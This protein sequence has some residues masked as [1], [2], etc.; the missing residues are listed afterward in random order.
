M[1]KKI[2][3]SFFAV[4]FITFTIVATLMGCDSDIFGNNQPTDITLS[5]TL[6]EFDTIKEIQGKNLQLEAT[7]T[8]KGGSK[9]KEVSWEFPSDDKAFKVQ[10]TAGG[11]LTFQ[12]YK[13]GTYVISA[14]AMYE[15]KAYKTAQ[16]VITINDALTHL[17]I[18]N[19]TDNNTILTDNSASMELM[20]GNTVTLAPVFTPESTSQ[21]TVLWSIDNAAVASISEQPGNKATLTAKS[22][23]T[24]TVSLISQDNTSIYRTLKLTVIE[25]G[26]EQK[27]GLS[28]I[29]VS[30]TEGAIEIGTS[31]TFTATVWD[32]NSNI[33]TSDKVAFSLTE[34]SKSA[35]QLGNVTDRSVSVT[36]THGGTGTLLA[37]FTRDGETVESKVPLSVTGNVENISVKSSYINLLKGAE[38]LVNVFYSPENTKEKGFTV[39]DYDPSIISVIENTADKDGSFYIRANNIGTTKVQIKSIYNNAIVAEIGIGVVDPKTKADRISRIEIGTP[40]LTVEPLLNENGEAYFDPIDLFASIYTISDNG[41]EDKNDNNYN[42]TF[43]SSDSSV[44]YVFDSSYVNADEG[45]KATL[46]VLKPGK[47]R[48]YAKSADNKTVTAYCDIT[49]NGTLKALIAENSAI[50]LTP[51]DKRTV[52]LTPNPYNAVMS[53]PSVSLSNDAVSA[54]IKRENGVYK[55][56]IEALKLGETTVSYYVDGKTVSTTRVTVG[57][58]ENNAVRTI[59]FKDITSALYL[60]Q[61]EDPKTFTVEALDSKGLAVNK[62]IELKPETETANEIVTIERV[63][64]TNTFTISPK[65]AGKGNWIFYINDTS[66]IKSVLHVEVGGS[67]VQGEDIRAIKAPFNS[68]S[69][70]LKDDGKKEETIKINTIPLGGEEVCGKLIWSISD[71]DVAELVTVPSDPTD[72][73][74]IVRAVGEG[75]A[76]IT[77]ET[78]KGLKTTINVRV[79]G[80]D[81]ATNTVISKAYIAKG[82]T[83]NWAMFSTVGESFELEAVAYN[84]DGSVA[85][86]ELFNWTYQGEGVKSLLMEKEDGVIATATTKASF[87]ISSMPQNGYDNPV[88]ITA[89]SVNN[90]AVRATFMVYIVASEPTEEKP[91]IIAEYSGVTLSLES[92]KT[93]KMDI[94][95]NV[96]P[97]SYDTSNME[98]T[99]SSTVVSAKLNKNTNTLSLTAQEAGNATV[100]V[101]DGKLSFDVSVNVVE[102]AIKED[103]K[104]TSIRL[105]RSYLSYDLADKA[106]Q[107]ITATVYKDGEEA[108]NEGV[109]WTSSD[110]SIVKISTSGKIAQVLPQDKVGTAFITATSIN[111]ANVS[112]SCSIEVIDSSKIA[113]TLRYINI[114]QTNVIL[115]EGDRMTLTV[116]GQPENLV[117]TAQLTWKSSKPDV[118]MVSNGTI[119]ALKEGEADITVSTVSDGKTFNAVCH[120]IVKDNKTEIK[121]VSSIKLSESIVRIPQDDMDKTFSINA[122]IYDQNSEEM[123]GRS[124]QWEVVNSGAEDAIEYTADNLSLSYIPKNPGKVIVKASIGAIKAEAIIYVAEGKGEDQSLK[125]IVLTPSV[126]IGINENYDLKATLIPA[127]ATDTIEWTVN[128]SNLKTTSSKNGKVLSVVSSKAG[129]YTLTASSLENPLISAT[130][131]VTVKEAIKEDEVTSVNLDVK[132]ILL[133]L[134]DKKLTSIKATVYKGGKVSDG[135]VE[136]KIDDSLKDVISYRTLGFNS[137]A[138]NKTNKTGEGYITAIS[139]DDGKKYAVCKVRVVDT[140][141]TVISD[142]ESANISS[143]TISLEKGKEH[144]LSVSTYPSIIPT[145]TEWYSSNE[146]VATVDTN[147]NIIA[148]GIGSATITASVH[149]REKTISLECRV[150]VY[151]PNDAISAKLIK[152]SQNVVYLKQD[153]MDKTVSVQATIIGSDNKEL[154][155]DSDGNQALVTWRIDNSNN[156]DA[157]ASISWADNTVLLTPKNAGTARV[158]AEYQGKE[159]SFIVVT[160][161]STTASSKEPTGVL[162]MPASLTMKTGDSAVISAYVQPTGATADYAFAVKEGSDVV[163]ATYSGNKVRIKAKKTGTAK[164]EAM[165]VNKPEIKTTLNITVVSST[166]KKVT[167]ISLDKNYIS[168]ELDTKALTTVSATAYV[169]G[170]ATKNIPLEWSLE[171]ITKNE[172]E[173]TLL[174]TYNTVSLT[175]K[176]VG[177]GYLVCR[178]KDNPDVYA[179]CRVEITKPE[180]KAV[181]AKRIELSKSL[182]TVSQEKMDETFVLDATV[183]GSD[184]KVFTSGSVS[185]TVTDPNSAIEYQK[186]DSS[187]FFSPRNAGV[188][189]VKASVGNVETEA[190]IIVGSAYSDKTLKGYTL[191][192]TR[193]VLEE[194]KSSIIRLLPIPADAENV[195]TI[196]TSSAPDIA[197]VSEINDQMVVTAQKV[198]SATITAVDVNDASIKAIANVTVVAKGVITSETVTALTL[199]KSHI[200]LDLASKDLTSVK[201]TVYKNGKASNGAVEWKIDESLK[202]VVTVPILGNTISIV[203]KAVGEGYIT[204]TSKDDRNFSARVY[205]QVIDSSILPDKGI[206]D[207]TISSQSITLKKG[208]KSTYTVSVLPEDLAYNTSWFSSDETIATVDKN[209]TVTA[210]NNGRATISARLSYKDQVKYV[211]STV[212]VYSESSATRPAFVTLSS[213]VIRLSM[214]SENT[215][216][217]VEARVYDENNV[218]MFGKEI[219]WSIKDSSVARIETNNENKTGSKAYLYPISAGSTIVTATVGNIE[220]TVLVIVGSKEQGAK[221]STTGIVFN[222]SSAILK[223]GETMVVSANLIPAGVDDEILYSITAPSI[224]SGEL[225]ADKTLTVKGANAGNANIIARSKKNPSISTQM[226]VNVKDSVKNA[227][228]AIKLDKT[229]IE[230]DLNEKALVSLKA[231]V[232]VDGKETIE[233]VPLVWSFT[234]TP[235][236]AI[237]LH[238]GTSANNVVYVSKAEV[239]SGYITCRADNGVYAQCYVEVIES[240]DP[241]YGLSRIVFSDNIINLSQEKMDEIHAVKATVYNTNNEIVDKAITWTL[242]PDDKATITKNGNVVYLKPLNAGEAILSAKV[243]DGESTITNSIKVIVGAAS[244]VSDELVKLLAQPESLV[245][246]KG[247]TSAISISTIPANAKDT[248]EW[249]MTNSSNARLTIETS[250]GTKRAKVEGLIVGKTTVTAYSKENP[251][252]KVEIPVSIVENNEAYNS[253][254][255]ALKLDKSAIYLDLAEKTMTTLKATV[256]VGGKASTKAVTNWNVDESLKEVISTQEIGN[257]TLSITKKSVGKG[258][259][260]ATVVEGGVTY[261]A[262]AYVEVVDTS[263]TTPSLVFITLSDKV[264]TLTEGNSATLNVTGYSEEAFKN[265]AITWS[266]DNEDVAVVARGKVTALKE[267]VARIKA[268]VNGTSISDECVVTVKKS[269]SPIVPSRVVVSEKNIFLT[270]GESHA[271]YAEIVPEGATATLTW[272]SSD[273]SIVKV[274]KDGIISAIKAGTANITVFNST[275]NITDSCSVTVKEPSGESKVTTAIVFNPRT[276]TIHKGEK[277]VINVNGSPVEAIDEFEYST[278]NPNVV[279]ILSDESDNT[280]VVFTA[281]GIGEAKI[282]AVS[283]NSPLVKAECIVKVVSVNTEIKEIT[284]IVLSNN[285]GKIYEGSKTLYVAQAYMGS[286]KA[287]AKIEWSLEGLTSAQAEIISADSTGKRAYLDAKKNGEGY[288]VATVKANGTTQT[289][290]VSTKTYVQILEKPTIENPTAPTVSKIV[291]SG[292]PIVQILQSSEGYTVKATVLDTNGDITD[293]NVSWNSSNEDVATILSSGNTALIIPNEAGQSIISATAEGKTESILVIVGAINT[294]EK[295]KGLTVR[296]NPLTIEV[297]DNWTLEATTLPVGAMDVGSFAWASDNPKVARVTKNATN[298]LKAD[299]VAASVGSAKITVYSLNNPLISATTEVEVKAKGS[300]KSDSVTAIELSKNQLSL[301]LGKDNA[302]SVD[303]IVYKNKVKS[304]S[305][306]VT[307]TKSETDAFT[308]TQIGSKTVNIVPVKEGEGYITAQS[309]DDA[310]FKASCYVRVTKTEIAGTEIS[311]IK[312]SPEAITL[313][314]NAKTTFSVSVYPSTITDYTVSW[315]SSNDTIVSVTED[316]VATAKSSGNAR[317]T[318]TIGYKGKTYS[319]YGT[320]SVSDD[321]VTLNRIELSVKDVTLRESESIQVSAELIPSGANAK[322]TWASSNANVARVNSNGVITGIK[323]GSAVITAHAYDEDMEA[324]VN[325]E[326]IEN[327]KTVTPGSIRLSTQI[328]QLDQLKPDEEKTV[329]ATVYAKEDNAPIADAVVTWTI[330]DESVAKLDTNKNVATLKAGDAGKTALKAWYGSLSSTAVIYSG[331]TPTS[332]TVLDRLS[333]SPSVIAIETDKTEKASVKGFP[334]GASFTP[335]WESNNTQVATI[336]DETKNANIVTINGVKEGQATITVKDANADKK[337]TL[338]VKVY[339]DISNAVTGVYLDKSGLSFDIAEKS[340][341]TV[342]AKVYVNKT[343]APSEKVK[344]TL[345]NEDLITGSDLVVFVPTDST[346]LTI[347]LKPNASRTIKTGKAYLRATSVKDTDMY[348]QVFIEVV[349]SSTAPVKVTEILCETDTATLPVGSTRTFRAVTYPDSVKADVRWMVIDQK[350]INGTGNVITTDIYGKVT[351]VSEGSATLKAYVY[352]SSPELSDTVAITVTATGNADE[353]SKYEIGS[354]RLSPSQLLLSQTATFPTTLTARIYDKSGKE[355]TTEQVNWNIDGI[356]DI[357]TVVRTQGNVLYLEAKS[358]GKGEIIASKTGADGKTITA[359]AYVVTGGVVNPEETYITNLTFNRSMPIYLVAGDGKSETA[360]LRYTPESKSAEGTVWSSRNYD[361][362]IQFATNNT[363]ITATGLKE[364]PANSPVVVT[365]TSASKDVNNNSLSADAIFKVVASKDELPEVTSLTLDK[366]RLVLD[367]SE[368]AVAAVTATAF[369]A[370]GKVVPGAKIEWELRNNTTTNVS[371]TNTTGPTVGVNKGTMPGKVELVATCGEVEIVCNVEVIDSSTFMGISVGSKEIRLVKGGNATISVYGTPSDMFKE[372]SCSVSGD[373]DAVRIISDGTKKNF[374]VTALKAGTAFLRFITEVNGKLYT[375]D[376]VVYVNDPETRSVNS[377]SFTPKSLYL[378]YEGA[379]ADLTTILY[380]K[381]GNVVQESVE[382][383]AEDPSIVELNKTQ[384]G[385]EVTA[386]KKGATSVYA[387]S[388]GVSSQSYIMVG[389]KALADDKLVKIIPSMDNVTMKKNQVQDVALTAVPASYQFQNLVVASN[390]TN[391]ATASIENGALRIKALGEGTAVITV[392]EA[393]VSTDITVT[394]TGI[395]QPA[396]IEFDKQ[397]VSLKQESTSSETVNAYVY[398]QDKTLL[399]L[400]IALWQTSDS[401]IA[402]ITKKNANSITVTPGNMG[403]AKVTANVGKVSSSFPVFVNAVEKIADAP[404]DIKAAQANIKLAVGDTTEVNVF[405]EPTNVKET[406]KG[407]TWNVKDTKIASIVPLSNG[408]ASVTG[409]TVGKT[410]ITAKSNVG[411]DGNKPS[412]VFNVTVVPETDKDVYRIELD[413]TEI[414]LNFSK[415]S[416]INAHLYKNNVEVDASEINWT[417]EAQQSVVKLSFV[418]GVSLTDKYTGSGVGI[419][420]GTAAGVV[421][422]VASYANT[423]SRA[424]VVIS[425]SKQATT[426]LTAVAI[427]SKYMVMEEGETV[428]FT[429]TTLPQIAGVTYTWNSSEKDLVEFIAINNNT[430]TLKALKKGSTKISVVATLAG[431]N[432]PVKDESVLRIE[433][434]GALDTTYKYS[435]VK[436]DKTSLTMLPNGSYATVTATLVDK[437][438]KEVEAAL[439]GWDILDYRGNVLVS[440][441]PN[442]YT[443]GTDTKTYSTLEAVIKAAK[444][445][446][447]SI[448]FTQFEVIGANNSIVH[449]TPTVSGIFFIEAKGPVENNKYVSSKMMLEVS[450]GITG[451]GFNSSYLHLIKGEKVQ[452]TVSTSPTNAQLTAYQWQEKVAT[453]GGKQLIDIQDATVSSAYLFGREIGTTAVE[454]TA[455]DTTGVSMNAQMTV[456]VHDPSYGTGGIRNISFDN[457]YA[458]ASYP[459]QTATYKATAY[460]MDGTTAEDSDITYK[461]FNSDGS[462]ATDG[463]ITRGEGYDTKIATFTITENGVRITPFAKGTVKVVATLNKDGAEF[464]AEMY[465][466][467]VGNSSQLTPSSSSI[468]LYTGGSAKID[469]TTDNGHNNEYEVELISEYTKD[470]HKIVGGFLEGTETVMQSVFTFLKSTVKGNSVTLGTKALLTEGQRKSG[471]NYSGSK[472]LLTDGGEG[473]LTE[474]QYNEIVATFPRTAAFKVTTADGQSSTIINVTVNQLPT[475]NSYPLELTLDISKVDLTPPFTTENTVKASLKDIANRETTGTINWYYYPVGSEIDEDDHK[476]DTKKAVDKDTISAYFSADGKTMYYT[477][478][479]SGLYRLKAE[480]VQNPQLT[481]IATI[482]VGGSVTG[483]TSSVGSSLRIEKGAS[484]TVSAVFTPESALARTAYFALDETIKAPNGAPLSRVI[485]NTKLDNNYLSITV[486]NG[487]ETGDTATIYG[488]LSTGNENRQM[489]RIIYPQTTAGESTLNSLKGKGCFYTLTGTTMKA[490]TLDTEGNVIDKLDTNGKPI[491]IEVFFY[492]VTVDVYANK[493]VYAFKASGATEV[494]PNDVKG[495]VLTYNVTASTNTSNTDN[496]F[497]NWDWVEAKLVGADT[498]MVYASSVPVDADGHS[499]YQATANGEV[500]VKTENGDKA[501]AVESGKYYPESSYFTTETKGL[502]AKDLKNYNSK[503]TVLR[504]FADIE[505]DGITDNAYKNAELVSNKD[506]N[507]FWFKATGAEFIAGTVYEVSEESSSENPDDKQYYVNSK[508]KKVKVFDTKDLNYA[509]PLVGRLALVEVPAPLSDL[510]QGRLLASENNSVYKFTLNSSAIPTEP[511]VLRAGISEKVKEENKN[512]SK[513]YDTE[514]TGFTDSDTNVFI[515]G[516]IQSISPGISE[517]KNNGSSSV[518]TADGSM[519]QLIEGASAIIKL[520]YNPSYTHQREVRWEVIGGSTV[521]NSYTITPS[522]DSTQLS[523]V[524]NKIDANKD[525]ETVHLRATSIYNPNVYCDFTVVIQCIVKSMSF[526]TKAMT[527]A[528]T[529]DNK[530]QPIYRLISDQINY[531]DKQ[532][533]DKVECYDYADVAGDAA[534]V[535]AYLIEMTPT[536][537]FGYNFKAEIIEGSNIG[538]LDTTDLDA[539]SNSFRF[540]PKGRVYEKYDENGKPASSAY[541]VEYGNVTIRVTCEDLNYSKDFTINYGASAGRI[542]RDIENPH[543]GDNWMQWDSATSPDGAHYLYGLEAIVLY[544]GETFPVTMIDFNSGD[545]GNDQG[546]F[547]QHWT[548]DS[549]DSFIKWYVADGYGQVCYDGTNYYADMAGNATASD[550][551]WTGGI[552]FAT[553]GKNI[554]TEKND[555]RYTDDLSDVEKEELLSEKG[556]LGSVCILKAE[557]QGIFTL[558]YTLI[559]ILKNSETGEAILDNDGNPC[560]ITTVGSIPVYVISRANQTMLAALSSISQLKV[561]AYLCDKYISK[562]N[563]DKWF[564]PARDNGITDSKTNLQAN[565]A[566]WRGKTFIAFDETHEYG[567]KAKTYY[568]LSDTDFGSGTDNTLDFSGLSASDFNSA[569]GYA[570]SIF[571]AEEESSTVTVN[572]SQTASKVDY[573]NN[574]SDVLAVS[575][576]NRSF[577][578]INF[579]NLVLAGDSGIAILKATHNFFVGKNKSADVQQ[580]EWV[581]NNSTYVE[582]KGNVLDFSGNNIESITFTNLDFENTDGILLRESTEL[583]SGN[584]LKSFAMI[585]CDFLN[586]QFYDGNYAWGDKNTKLVQN[587]SFESVGI[588]KI[589]MSNFTNA[590]RIAF[591]GTVGAPSGE[592]SDFANS[593]LILE[594]MKNSGEKD[595]V[596]FDTSN[597]SDLHFNKMEI[598]NSNLTE[599]D[600]ERCISSVREMEIDKVNAGN[601]LSIRGQSL[602]KLSVTGG[603]TLNAQKEKAVFA[604]GAFNASLGVKPSLTIDNVTIS[605]MEITATGNGSNDAPSGFNQISVKNSNTTDIEIMGVGSYSNTE[606]VDIANINSNGNVKITLSAINSLKNLNITTIPRLSTLTLSNV[607]SKE[608]ANVRIYNAGYN[609]NGFTIEG[610]GTVVKMLEIGRT[611]DGTQ[612]KLASI[613]NPIETPLL[614]LNGVSASNLS[615]EGSTI[616]KIVVGDSNINNAYANYIGT[617]DLAKITNNV[618]LYLNGTKNGDNRIGTINATSKTVDAIQVTNEKGNGS[619]TVNNFNLDGATIHENSLRAAIK[620]VGGDN[621]DQ[622]TAKRSKVI[623]SSNTIKFSGTGTSTVTIPG[624]EVVTTTETSVARLSELIG[625]NEADAK[626]QHSIKCYDYFKQESVPSIKLDANICTTECKNFEDGGLKLHYHAPTGEIYIM[627][628]HEK[629]QDIQV[630]TTKDLSAKELTEYYKIVGTE[631]VIKNAKDNNNDQ[632]LFKYKYSSGVTIEHIGE[633]IGNGPNK[634]HNKDRI[635]DGCVIK[636]TTRDGKTHYFQP[637]SLDVNNTSKVSGEIVLDKP[638]GANSYAHPTT[639]YEY[640]GVTGEDFLTNAK[641][642]NEP[643]KDEN[644]NPWYI[645]TSYLGPYNTAEEK[646]RVGQILTENNYLQKDGSNEVLVENVIELIKKTETKTHIEGGGTITVANKGDDRCQNIYLSEMQVY[647]SFENASAERNQYN[648]VKIEVALDKLKKLDV[649]N[650]KLSSLVVQSTKAIEEIKFYNNGLLGSGYIKVNDFVYNNG[651]WSNATSIPVKTYAYNCNIY[652]YIRIS[653][654]EGGNYFGTEYMRLGQDIEKS[655]KSGAIIT[656][657]CAGDHHGWGWHTEATVTEL[658]AGNYHYSRSS[659]LNWYESYSENFS[660]SISQI[661][662]SGQLIGIWAKSYSNDWWNSAHIGFTI[663]PFG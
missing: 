428:S 647:S 561:P 336:N 86:G 446:A 514:T 388:N 395:A 164:I 540:V 638:H 534:L 80:R 11:V 389:E 656:G 133:D 400:D 368:K 233:N 360:T 412:T 169:D 358:A 190:K 447:I 128:N 636:V 354:I 300:I 352:G 177:N 109:T 118:V 444:D 16:C 578:K 138:I 486:N 262:K 65:N 66:G 215:A 437:N 40:V 227:V 462:S 470:G 531:P 279:S 124:V 504:F 33:I 290:S 517:L 176:A 607:K 46:K 348:S 533:S 380:D 261:T 642:S 421:Y 213:P 455:T 267:G 276:L 218:E 5:S 25:S 581:K 600:F 28:K 145:T 625:Y 173:Y 15:G 490:W 172:L 339:D 652:R 427:T 34:E 309:N 110:E 237:T 616:G 359:S 570:S 530:G 53:M 628:T 219:V 137:I 663:Y 289:E 160:G 208:E 178:S 572:G 649:A 27:F 466:N 231:T 97:L 525:Q 601:K 51:G 232:Y 282:T 608:T 197:T 650:C 209:G 493:T 314:K 134:A 497:S 417:V 404:S 292:N 180:E 59:T 278:N 146:S 575:A 183:Y 390:R 366:T 406:G 301:V 505:T 617:L 206:I 589:K 192:P 353:P 615:L 577:Q 450:G 248:I 516:K 21:Q 201:A 343:F 286:S 153:D 326:V 296:P 460:Y 154:T 302:V 47:A 538:S 376:A 611:K 449:V 571:I 63:G 64:D 244:S 598:N 103:P 513:Y 49:V 212:N 465:L 203:K 184:D 22:K 315:S 391:V 536:P 631:E 127:S 330:E 597:A 602:Q 126:T 627:E 440:W 82:S 116:S 509:S 1:F 454:Y 568:G 245:L 605:S 332:S 259:I 228:T 188:A 45:Y 362:Y 298:E 281:K 75:T 207:A 552:S 277:A 646:A 329:I 229:Y 546:T 37:T 131:T 55:V 379:K 230:F 89:T 222:P 431:Y 413:K 495:S 480:C 98:V 418:D 60:K 566:I 210:V 356:K 367:L 130:T 319:Q 38:E 620:A 263:K 468:I 2:S 661:G 371:I 41:S 10:S 101:S 79:F 507:Q 238:Q 596:V 6:M 512:D 494:N 223:K 4:F 62:K 502:E 185:W 115:D 506:V 310:T 168:L 92:E 500:K 491:S 76:T 35:F 392:S 327:Q 383:K 430:V 32:A 344:W 532:S 13:S 252:I 386:L 95:Y 585:D 312:V 140:S 658:I 364:T 83:K 373:V 186:T 163:E 152:F 149:G 511:L 157:V 408:K 448:P 14:H 341:A 204:A 396:F 122:T 81:V 158:Y 61:D 382:Y 496:T 236:T 434:K 135:A 397:S 542:V 411:V 170:K 72:F 445:S 519:I 112:A 626:K 398:D 294:Q 320:V 19:V 518:N 515:G 560:Y 260:T 308:I 639:F 250:S 220:N 195:N 247:T 162:F 562:T 234:G 151:K 36:A 573:N 508:G 554:G 159:N 136:W 591:S 510:E 553:S 99:S 488:K 288:I 551:K 117:K 479:L 574:L 241:V 433:E 587:I 193:L 182:M 253:R 409:K 641:G 74:R 526:T 555:P 211:T 594:N 175:K 370:D 272:S 435:A 214:E 284:S 216:T 548:D 423:S 54:S 549:Y 576:L 471:T 378:A 100:T 477:P 422:V 181:I 592:G 235:N 196:W 420:A 264:L 333:V 634:S 385:V 619:L 381:N 473:T 478:K 275:Y 452:T 402:K 419:E 657:E 621:S 200:V 481:S 335:E 629:D 283:K 306:T 375:A 624:K 274:S 492:S 148:K 104:I 429:A 165:L 265:A 342:S 660:A 622:L 322:L 271:L 558:N 20:V 609:D 147:G 48:I 520:S 87:R 114:S 24:A 563:L 441:T 618:N 166:D 637:F 528:N 323:K 254:I 268:T 453:A 426:G 187:F 346:G 88:I 119:T 351:A 226:T 3:S 458:T 102:K 44:V 557:K 363:S 606:N 633:H 90:P 580:G 106:L 17:R 635:M 194:N 588:N 643:I 565:A 399:S 144:T 559:K 499:L 498:N 73:T 655:E 489:L 105:D 224:L 345:L 179:K 96:Y 583:A 630:G 328:V 324:S 337:A 582:G 556:L 541:E 156:N 155:T 242:T 484:A 26:A 347:G 221:T 129:V 523:F 384:T 303:A 569:F 424:Q 357:A 405:Y 199:D 139:K 291:L 39:S 451:V 161:P 603:T 550:R 321:A 141:T 377:I 189:I 67:A 584:Y 191:S 30:P 369:D 42:V 270:R 52:T 590:T 485:E 640:E 205:V 125:S 443:F 586:G 632:I 529:E 349:D 334:A 535:D 307:W 623:A 56:D 521:T 70:S 9:S 167:S 501:V 456:Q 142:I 482:N 372:A 425:D 91:I 43:E 361:G 31:Q 257:N 487:A 410:S 539:S 132:S 240:K 338:A 610:K 651:A 113:E 316:G 150:T 483:V 239:G 394:V 414:A 93:K 416:F 108:S 68:F 217:E 543:E 285:S 387:Y 174:D 604:T 474:A 246:A 340:M 94:K 311:A 644:D 293:D 78:K 613:N 269:S 522:K 57:S 29:E 469:L 374:T 7:I 84:N 249:S 564:M 595:P 567:G 442:G 645:R 350:P 123:W 659:N 304:D 243:T 18:M 318:A 475:G 287:D 313:K 393:S 225:N 143:T 58:K 120:V 8:L 467:I 503:K 202:D 436:L 653:S 579:E 524:A 439:S 438:N 612:S 325:V 50:T 472:Y 463:N 12:I 365:A 295:L 648:N 407:L 256:E 545:L 299:V 527:R 403:E 461:V 662:K 476:L 171:G 280:K 85:S 69:L 297:G 464:T 71:N 111:N 593:Y 77:A 258:Y 415:Q 251:A 544:E 266:T 121:T 432:T 401:S 537:K 198:G 599:V 305:A 614:E 107:T 23:G 273:P 547:F 331:L 317:V 457:V 459:Y 355:L 255:T 654:D